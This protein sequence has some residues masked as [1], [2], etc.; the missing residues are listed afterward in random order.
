MGGSQILTIGGRDGKP[1]Q[2]DGSDLTQYESYHSL[3]PNAQGLAIFDLTS[4][5]WLDQYTAGAPPYKQSDPVKH[6]TPTHSST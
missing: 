2:L 5:T 1:D 3:D 4:L 6:F